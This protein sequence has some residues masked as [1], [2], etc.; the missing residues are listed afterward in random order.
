MLAE[1]TNLQLSQECHVLKGALGMKDG[2]SDGA[3]GSQARLLH[4]LSKV[5]YRMPAR[6][7]RLHLAIHER[8]RI[9]CACH[10]ESPPLNRPCFCHQSQGESTS[11]AVQLAEGQRHMQDLQDKLE[12]AHGEIG[13]LQEVSLQP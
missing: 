3:L 1:E 9:C 2:L 8:A 5:L 13:R 11:L 12:R 4:Q 6:A 10:P 7:M